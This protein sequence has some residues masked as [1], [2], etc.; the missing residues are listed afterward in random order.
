[1]VKDKDGVVGEQL[2]NPTLDRHNPAIWKTIQQ[3]GRTIWQ[4]PQVTRS[5]APVIPDQQTLTSYLHVTMLASCLKLMIPHCSGIA[6]VIL[7][8]HLLPYFWFV[9]QDFL[10]VV[11][12]SAV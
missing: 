12:C 1:M 4:I 6:K 11:R 9:I 2:T 7:E 5:P 8:L 3:S 10:V